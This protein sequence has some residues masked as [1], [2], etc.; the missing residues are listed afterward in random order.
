MLGTGRRAW[1][2]TRWGVPEMAEVSSTSA[3]NSPVHEL[4]RAGGRL[5][6]AAAAAALCCASGA[7]PKLGGVYPPA[8]IPM[9]PRGPVAPPVGPGPLLGLPAY[10]TPARR[11]QEPSPP[12]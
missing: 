11:R 12:P 4:E 8:C 5:T 3:R 7:T 6:V 2:E 1:C 9:L 10:A